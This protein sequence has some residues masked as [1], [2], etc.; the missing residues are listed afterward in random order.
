MKKLNALDIY[1]IFSISVLVLYAIAEF[2]FSNITGIS[3][4]TLTTCIYTAFGGEC[5]MTA[6]IQISKR[7]HKGGEHDTEEEHSDF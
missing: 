3:H 7:F 4:D 5:L 6:L 1:V 2:V